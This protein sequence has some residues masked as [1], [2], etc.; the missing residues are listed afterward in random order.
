MQVP[1]TYSKRNRTIAKMALSLIH[2][3]RGTMMTSSVAQKQHRVGLLEMID[4]EPK[5]V[6]YAE[7][8]LGTS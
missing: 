1:R 3:E 8:K 5:E 6:N 2:N 4:L 7:I